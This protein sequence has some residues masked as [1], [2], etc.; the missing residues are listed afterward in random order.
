[1]TVVKVRPVYHP[2]QA[3]QWNGDLDG[4]PEWV[5]LS[6][7]RNREGTLLHVRPSGRQALYLGEWLV[8]DLDGRSNYYTSEEFAREFE[9]VPE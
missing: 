5:R 6:C 8:R 9:R 3:W 4:A 1:M 7:F 2:L